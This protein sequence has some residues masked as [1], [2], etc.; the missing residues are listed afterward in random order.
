MRTV[1]GEERLAGMVRRVLVVGESE[2]VGVPRRAVGQL[3]KASEKVEVLW[4]VGAVGVEDLGEHVGE[5][6]VG[7]VAQLRADPRRR[8]AG[9]AGQSL[10]SLLLCRGEIRHNTGFR[11]S[12]PSPRTLPPRLAFSQLTTLDLGHVILD[13]AATD[14]LGSAVLPSLHTLLVSAL[15][16]TTPSN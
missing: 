2:K 11:I 3:L 7:N 4:V 13:S 6:R 16:P 14:L 9:L 1:R 8:G 10:K 15:Y 5:L 12:A